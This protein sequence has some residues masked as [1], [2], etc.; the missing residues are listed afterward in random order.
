MGIGAAQ[1]MSDT[2]LVGRARAH[3]AS[4]RFLEFSVKVV[5]HR[6]GIYFGGGLW[7]KEQVWMRGWFS[8]PLVPGVCGAHTSKT[9]TDG[10]A[11]VCGAE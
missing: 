4:V 9:A 11:D 6:N 5:R 7:K 8:R 2:E 1:F 10:A 3:V